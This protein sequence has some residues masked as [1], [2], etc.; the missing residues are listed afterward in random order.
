MNQEEFLR[1]REEAEMEMSDSE[2]GESTSGQPPKRPR[3]QED[4]GRMTWGLL[5][6]SVVGSCVFR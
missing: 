6:H 4:I 2:D 3:R 5:G 1:D